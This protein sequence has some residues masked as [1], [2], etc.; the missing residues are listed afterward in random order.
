MTPLAQEVSKN[1]LNYL[2][3]L[4]EKLHREKNE[5]NLP[6]FMLETEDDE[7]EDEDDELE[8][9]DFVSLRAS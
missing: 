9:E 5:F 2:Q 3:A 7:D 1:Y 6:R 8:D 4:Q